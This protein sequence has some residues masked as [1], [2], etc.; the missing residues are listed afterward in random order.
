R[1]ALQLRTYAGAPLPLPLQMAAAAVWSDEAHVEEIR[2]LYRRKYEMADQIL[3]NVPGYAA[4]EAGF[5]LWLPVPDGEAAALR[6]WKKTG[7][8]VL[9]GA[10]LAQG[11]GSENPGHEYI[12]VALV[13]TE[14]ETERG[15]TA[16]R[17]V[18]YA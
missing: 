13:A 6:L 4:P 1:E 17:D 14:A 10:Y 11:T 7:V 16:I 8:R 15:L 5:F 3:G 9:P 18:L 12:R 2:A